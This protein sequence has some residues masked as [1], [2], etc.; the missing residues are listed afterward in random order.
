MEHD[1]TPWCKKP[2]LRNIYF[3]LFL[4]CMGIEMTS[5]FDS[6]I[7]NALKFPDPWNKCTSY[8]LPGLP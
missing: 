5:G 1:K 3:F 2:D 4:V 6:I 7:I 8:S